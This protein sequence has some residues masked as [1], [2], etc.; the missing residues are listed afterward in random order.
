LNLRPPGYEQGEP[1]LIR[2]DPS[3]PSPFV[4]RASASAS[5]PSLPVPL[6][7]V[8]SWSRI[9]SRMLTLSAEASTNAPL[10][11]ASGHERRRSDIRDQVSLV[12]VLPSRAATR[13][14]ASSA[15]ADPGSRATGR[16]VGQESLG[17]ST[18]TA[19]L[20][21]SRMHAPHASGCR[22]SPTTAVL[23][24]FTGNGQ[25]WR[26]PQSDRPGRSARRS[27]R[28]RVVMGAV[29]RRVT[30]RATD[31]LHGSRDTAKRVRDIVQRR[32]RRVA[33]GNRTPRLP[34]IPA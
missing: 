15:P 9:W 7:P 32:G 1:G 2:P 14:S 10:V 5:H 25:G 34:Q 12:D 26:D 22:P 21:R 8:A 27:E 33:G 11:P 6:R 18:V 20:L 28:V 16:W 29:R 23:W 31:A 4:A 30:R 17:R 3:P 19:C 13:N 24:C